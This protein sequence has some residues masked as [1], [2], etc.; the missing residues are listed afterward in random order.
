LLVVI[1]IIAILAALL[2]PSMRTAQETAKTAKCSAN[3]RQ[4]GATLFLF[5][6][7]HNQCFPES[8]G[9]ISW[10]RTDPTPPGGSG[11]GPWMQ[12]ISG[13]L[14]NGSATGTGGDPQNSTVGSIFTCPSSS[15]V[16]SFDK[17]YS[18]F[19]GT[20]AAYLATGGFA[21]VNKNLITCPAQTILSGDITSW[22]DASPNDDADKDDYTQNPISAKSTFHNGAVNLLFADGHVATVQWNS[23]TGY[24]DPTNM[25]T[26]YEGTQSPQ[27]G[28]NGF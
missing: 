24:F 18:Y 4:I 26:H 1:A 14:D 9:V 6:A 5:A 10:G 11:Q 27:G 13:Y 16:N 12:Q 19:N 25:C 28:Y 8:G 22:S 7:D 3:L 20:R 2:I 17:Y 21:A 23:T 15:V